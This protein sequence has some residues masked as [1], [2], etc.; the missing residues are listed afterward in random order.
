MVK[1]ILRNTTRHA[2]IT[3]HSQSSPLYQKISLLLIRLGTGRS[4][5]SSGCSP[6]AQTLLSRAQSRPSTLSFEPIMH[7]WPG[8]PVVAFSSSLDDDARGAQFLAPR[9]SNQALPKRGPCYAFPGVHG[10]ALVRPIAT[11]QARIATS[12]APVVK[13]NQVLRLESQW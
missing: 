12:Q 7:F 5:S 1:A 9:I 2:S 11:S 8:R 10:L 3:R 13:F 4:P 6:F